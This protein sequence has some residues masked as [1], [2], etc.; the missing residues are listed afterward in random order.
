[1][2][3][4]AMILATAS[5]LATSAAWA[6]SQRIFLKMSVQAVKNWK[7]LASYTELDP[8]RGTTRGWI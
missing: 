3:R 7:W 5:I 8:I 4:L 1:M 2:K 6:D